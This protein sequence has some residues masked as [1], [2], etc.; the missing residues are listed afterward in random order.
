MTDIIFTPAA[1]DDPSFTPTTTTNHNTL[2]GR[3]TA[4][5]HPASAITTDN[6]WNGNLTS[7][8]TNLAAVLDAIDDLAL[9][10]GGGAVDSV[11]GETGTVVLDAADVD[12]VPTARTVTAG[13][14][15]TGGGDLSANRTLAVAY[16]TG[17]GTAAQGNDSRLSDA[18]TP[19]A[20]AAS[21]A[22][23]GADALTDRPPIHPGG[24]PYRADLAGWQAK[25]EAATA[26]APVDVVLITDSLWETATFG[27]SAGQLLHRM[28]NAAAGVYLADPIGTSTL[29]LPVHAQAGAGPTSATST[30]GTASTTA[31]GGWGSTLTDGQVLTH[32]AT[33]TGF[34]VLYRTE[35]GWGTLTI[36]D[37]AGGTVLGTVS[38]DAAATSGNMWTSAA[39]SDASHTLH[40]TS[41]GTTRVEM[42]MPTRETHVRVWPCGRG[43]ATTDDYIDVPAQALDFIGK[44][45]TAGTL[46]LVLVATGTNDDGEYATDIPALLAAIAAATTADVALWLPYMQAGFTHVEMDASRVAARAAGVPLIDASVVADQIGT[47]DGVHPNPQG[48]V[49]M[50]SHVSAVLSGD[51][52]GAAIR[53]AGAMAAGRGSTYT[54]VEESGLNISGDT[55]MLRTAALEVSVGS[56]LGILL[57]SPD[58]VV[59]LG[60]AQVTEGSDPAAAAASKVKV[61]AKND[62]GRS[63]LYTRDDVGVRS[64]AFVDDISS[65]IPATIIDAAGDLIVGTAADTAGRLAI[66]TNGHVL[67]ADSAQT[68]GVKWAAPA[69]PTAHASSHQDGGGDEL[70]LDGSQI[71]T[72]T[73]G[74]ARLG[75]GTASSAT[76]LRGDQT[77]GRPGLILPA[78]SGQYHGLQTRAAN[79]TYHFMITITGRMALVPVFVEPGSYDALALNQT[80][81]GT[82]TWRFGL[83]PSD[84]TTLLP[85]GLAL[86]A[87]LGTLNMSTTTGYRTVAASVSPTVPTL[88]WAGVLLD[89]LT[90]APTVHCVGGGGGSFVVDPPWTPNTMGSNI[91]RNNITR[92]ATGVTTGAMPATCP[93]TSWSDFGP[94]LALR[95]A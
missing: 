52:I 26:E 15:L 54:R 11:N 75:S 76:F 71:T 23:G 43:G 70:A 22:I 14:G 9:G 38:C 78:Q 12:A 93:A 80:V 92:T 44:L 53:L 48:R 33:A 95:G 27:P 20:H 28:L 1:D 68:A 17:A 77:W 86:I 67:T 83:Y 3:S 62:G 8:G 84:P 32:V 89:A 2:P 64:V 37:G 7:A 34:V 63:R 10:G 60:V 57:G 45:D 72:G 47:I 74:T 6:D 36:R 41:T 35:P 21:H 29:P 49:V 5:A 16:G 81:V 18:R 56:G 42:V 19:T 50:A 88:Y 79:A 94:W 55:Y 58:G 87:D 61:Y 39:L 25:F 59:G 13:T 90:T 30:Q 40:I 91:T 4:D 65:G 66:G 46:G 73:V 85:D 69:A 31:T 82:S 51:P 24:V